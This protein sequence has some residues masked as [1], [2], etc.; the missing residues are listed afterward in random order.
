MPILIFSFLRVQ[1]KSILLRSGGPAACIDREFS[2]MGNLPAQVSVGT[3]PAPHA[4]LA[5]TIGVGS[6][7]LRAHTHKQQPGDGR[8]CN[9]WRVRGH[10]ATE[11]F[12]MRNP[13]DSHG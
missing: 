8:A 12:L 11:E 2:V 4:C 3:R 6:G 5:Q 1:L 13:H 9:R 10:I 7:P